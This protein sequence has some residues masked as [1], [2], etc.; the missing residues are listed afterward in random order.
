MTDVSSYC[1]ERKI[2]LLIN[3]Y[4]KISRNLG[5]KFLAFQHF[6]STIR[7]GL[8]RVQRPGA[9]RIGSVPFST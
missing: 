9:R 1:E 6:T 5:G 7:K 3:V 2:M 4:I 8:V